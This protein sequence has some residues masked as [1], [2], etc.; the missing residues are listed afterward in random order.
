MG[1]A[2][3]LA[4]GWA[5]GLAMDR[6]LEYETLLTK[7]DNDFENA[8][9]ARLVGCRVGVPIDRLYP[10]DDK[11]Y[12]AEISVEIVGWAVGS[13][14]GREEIIEWEDPAENMELD[15]IDCIEA[16]VEYEVVG[17]AVGLAFGREEI[18]EWEDPAESMELDRIDCIEAMVEYEVV[19][20]AVGLAF[21]REE[22]IEWAEGTELDRIDCIE[23]M[24][25]YEV[26]G[27][28]KMFEWGADFDKVDCVDAMVECEG[29]RN[30]IE[31][32]LEEVGWD[33][34]VEAMVE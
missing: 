14:L 9:S 27:W 18:I 11:A 2:V 22:M 17:W 28:E 1:W 10:L 15:R 20:W 6:L 21:G 29:A 8:D 30:E 19:G 25:E 24:V 7:V 4:M 34:G 31:I 12:D 26:V 33:V 3:G 23:A 13:A 32:E 5:V 16:M